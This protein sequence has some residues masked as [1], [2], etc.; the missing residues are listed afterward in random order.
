[1]WTII[2]SRKTNSPAG[3]RYPDLP[4]DWSVEW[5]DT[6]ARS[7]LPRRCSLLTLV[8]GTVSAEIALQTADERIALDG[9]SLQHGYVL[10]PPEARCDPQQIPRL[11]YD[12]IAA[13]T[14]QLPWLKAYAQVLGNNYYVD[15]WRLWAQALQQFKA[16]SVGTALRLATRAS[17]CARTPAQR[18]V[19]YS[20]V[21]GMRIASRRFEEAA[22][23]PDPQPS[24]P[25]TLRSFLFEAKG[26]GLVMS[27]RPHEA[28]DC[29]RRAIELFGGEIR[30]RRAHLYL[31]NISAL[32]RL[33]MG[34]VAGALN[35]EKEIAVSHTNLEQRDWRLEYINSINLARLYCRL[36]NFEQ[37]VLYYRKAFET[38]LGTRSEG[39]CIYTN[40]CF[41][42]LDEERG[43]PLDSFGYRVRA[44][45]HWVSS[46]APEALSWRVAGAITGRKLSITDN[47]V[48]VVSA[49][50]CSQLIISAKLAGLEQ[51]ARRM[52]D[53]NGEEPPVFMRPALGVCHGTVSHAVLGPGWSILT[54]T[55][56]HPPQIISEAF[57]RLRLMLLQLI[58]VLYARARL[59]VV[60]TLLID[61]C[62]GREIPTTVFELLESA[63]RFRVTDVLFG[64][65]VFHMTQEVTAQLERGFESI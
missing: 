16:G 55:T 50:L 24:I 35:I 61:D 63:I 31:L 57:R 18:G 45:M 14:R 47:L 13:A 4:S 56:V 33:K 38:T 58:R 49:A 48:E 42:R 12:R 44:A 17:V 5:N 30:D 22:S 10:V 23:A 46:E 20:L 8:P 19:L 62:F 21:Q 39:D 7:V 43:R 1:M 40:V 25:D 29:F 3:Q 2:K 11:T 9:Y 53:A 41:A 65:S 51:C 26:W 28:Q 36:G 32:S 15:P 52:Q 59:P 6:E 34:D 54:G 27:D 64:E 37:A 60:G